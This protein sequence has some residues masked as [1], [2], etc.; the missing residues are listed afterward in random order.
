MKLA[1]TASAL[2]LAAGCRGG[3]VGPTSAVASTVA[4]IDAGVP[5]APADVVAACDAS[6]LRVAM[7]DPRLAQARDRERAHDFGPAARLAEDARKAATL[8]NDE[9]CAWGYVIGRLHLAAGENAQAA[10]ELDKLTDCPLREYA[11]LRA[12]Q[13]HARTG[14]ADLAID[15]ARAAGETIAMRDEAKLVLAE[16]IATKGDRG[17]ALPIWRALLTA[18]PRSSRWVDTSVRVAT[19]ILD[20]VDGDP[21]A[22]LPE[23]LEVTTRVVVEA[24]KLA[25]S[26]GATS[27]RYKTIAMMRAKDPSITDAFSDADRARRAQV[28]LEIGEPDKALA[29]ASGVLSEGKAPPQVLCKAATTAANAVAKNKAAAADAWGKAI[30]VCADDA[31]AVALY[32]GAKASNGAKRSQE[33]LDRFA[34]VER[35]FPKHRLADDA[36]FQSALIARD[37]GDDATYLARMSSLADDYPD[38]DM[39]PEALFRVALHH[40]T[41]GEW[42][43]AKAPLDR[44]IELTP[45]DRHWMTAGRAAYFRARVSAATGD[46]A[47]ARKR[48][49]RVIAETPLSFYMTQSY[50]RLAAIDPEEATRALEEAA[51]AEA[52]GPGDRDLPAVKTEAFALARR[53]LEVGETDWARR[54]MARSGATADDAPPEALWCVGNLYTRA[55]APE[56]GHAFARGRAIEFLGHYPTGRWRTVWEAAFPKAF[57]PLVARESTSRGVPVSLSWAIMREESDFFAEAKS[58]S[59]AYGLMQLIVP[60]AK[61]VAKGTN[62]VADETTLKKPEVN[63]ALGTKHLGELRHAFPSNVAFAIASY[64]AGMGAVSRWLARGAQD[65][66]LWVEQIPYDET[67]GYVKRVLA[68][69]AA[70]AYLYDNPT[71]KEVLSLPARAER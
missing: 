67:R 32:Q 34:E 33:A 68:S 51:R 37:A 24:P 31:L 48:W 16:A 40:M 7:D 1:V 10:T 44:I 5:S 17:A 53:L 36:R 70:Y 59:N 50:A 35:K 26:S 62:I 38:G 21:V 58:P 20:G 55:G 56:I 63:I 52:A 23:A 45:H 30:A 29:E 71:L 25:E 60:T 9:R 4:T 39:R 6:T 49:A 12:S 2:L 15:R 64:N 69:V 28:W 3:A 66:D 57:E 43:S 14:N 54:E 41:H 42:V 19:A 65:F 11:A 13:A 8:S 61:M 27:A 18:Q 22:H 47:D 46:L